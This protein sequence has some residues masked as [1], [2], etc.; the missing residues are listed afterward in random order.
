[1]AIAFACPSCNARFEVND[2]MAG[3]KCKCTR[4]GTQFLVPAAT[5]VAR[6]PAPPAAANGADDDDRRRAKRRTDDDEDDRPRAKRRSGDDDDDDRARV[7]S[8]RD[9]DDD[10]GR[11]KRRKDDDDDEDERPRAKRGRHDDD[12]DE[13]DRPR[14][15]GRKYDDDDDEDD[16]RPRRRSRKRASKKGLFIGIGVAAVLLIGVGLIAYFMWFSSSGP[17]AEIKY[18]PDNTQMVAKVQVKDLLAS[19]AYKKLKGEFGDM[20][21]GGPANLDDL[22]KHVGLKLNDIESVLV[23][24]DMTGG[25]ENVS[26]VVKT[27]RSVKDSELLSNIKEGKFTE[28][29]VGK[30]TMH[31][32]GDLAFCVAE[33][34]V[35]V[36]APPDVLKKV[37]KRDK[38]PDM[39]STMKAAIKET[40]FGK[41]VSMAMDLKAVAK[42]AGG[43][44]GGRGGGG[45]FMGGLGGFGGMGGAA[46]QLNGAEGLSMTVSVKS[47]ISAK[48]AVICKDS[49]TASDAAKQTNDGL[50]QLK[51][52]MPGDARDMLASIKC[53]SSGSRV[54][55]TANIDV[56]KLLKLI[57]SGGGIGGGGNMHR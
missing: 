31:E 4:C 5:A 2:T 36:Y 3:K 35:V 6:K 32:K 29:K 28:S 48:I 52:Q 39:S 33:S 24:A 38:D 17:G 23:G 18:L 16:D 21:K 13:D 20:M 12:E 9:D 10:R 37:L 43:G 46:D 27:T 19:D 56:S 45:G 50:K 11:V 34:S 30:Y 7:K 41:T 14:A 42:E 55:L 15:K 8:R 47:D 25:K 22:E 57:K 44:K 54:E 49:K 51:D 26:I 1:M 40:D 53:S